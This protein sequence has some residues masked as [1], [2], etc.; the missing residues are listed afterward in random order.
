MKIIVS[1][2][3][4]AIGL[5]HAAFAFSLVI[6][7]LVFF[8]NRRTHAL[9]K[10]LAR[11]QLFVMGARLEVRGRERFDPEKSYFIMGNHQSLFDVFVIP[12]AVSLFIVAVEA[13]SHFS[14][15]VWGSFTTRWGNIP[16]ARSERGKALAALEK[17]GDI[18]KDGVSLL[19]LPEGHRTM[20]GDIR[21][22]K[23]GPFYLALEAGVDILPFA[24]A[25]V[26][27]YKSKHSWLLNPGKVVV[28]FGEP[29]AYEFFKNMSVDE[30][31]DETRARMIRLKDSAQDRI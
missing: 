9:A 21:E 16:I 5:I 15:P 19:I 4:W 11:S 18:L 25:G 24:M 13:A 22:F 1:A 8:S 17:A 14:W 20:T 29:I 28:E 10:A 23:K 26:Y 30:I 27:E 6:G 3:L 7:S 31:K 2:V 12:P